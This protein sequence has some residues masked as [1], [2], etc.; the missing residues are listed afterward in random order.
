MIKELL[1]NATTT[2]RADIKAEAHRVEM[3]DHFK[4][5]RFEFQRNNKKI[6]VERVEKGILSRG[7]FTRRKD[8]GAEPVWYKVSVDGKYLNGDGWYGFVNPPIMVA[9]GTKRTVEDELTKEKYEVDNFK[10]DVFAAAKSMISQAV[11]K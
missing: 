11:I 3:L 1:R 7:K 9:D 6:R 8:G 4:G 10:E 5:G 2:E